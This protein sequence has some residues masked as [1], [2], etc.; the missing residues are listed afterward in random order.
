MQLLKCNLSGKSYQVKKVNALAKLPKNIR[1]FDTIFFETVKH[2]PYSGKQ[3]I[4]INNSG[5][6]A[7]LP[8]TEKYLSTN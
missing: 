7:T 2:F 1:Y 4:Y 8:T 5:Y 3:D 6:F